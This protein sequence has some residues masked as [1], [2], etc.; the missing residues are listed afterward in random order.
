M[1]RLALQSDIY[2][3]IFYIIYILATL[4]SQQVR[5]KTQQQQHTHQLH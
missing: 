4:H 3:N 2:V 1:T 5:L